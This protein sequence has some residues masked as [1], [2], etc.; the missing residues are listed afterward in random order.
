MRPCRVEFEGVLAS[1]GWA[2]IAKRRRIRRSSR[3]PDRGLLSDPGRSVRG[4]VWLDA[5]RWRE[6]EGAVL[7]EA[8]ERPQ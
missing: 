7:Q 5:G 6:V 1:D 4:Q 8:V 3:S 2:R